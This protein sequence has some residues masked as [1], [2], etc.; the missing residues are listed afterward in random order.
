MISRRTKRVMLGL[1][2][3]ALT[4]VL[5]VTV[6]ARYFAAQERRQRIAEERANLQA[7]EPLSVTAARETRE[8]RRSYSAQLRPFA[9][10]R[11]AAEAQGRLDEILAQ[12]GDRVTQGQTLARI[13][14]TLA[15]LNLESAEATLAAAQAQLDE[16][17]RQLQD[18]EILG[19]SRA[20][21]EAEV[22]GLRAQLNVQEREVNRW[23]VETRRQAE[24]LARHQIRAPFDGIL[25][26]RLVE[27]GDTVALQ[28]PLLRVVALDPLRVIFFVSEAEISSFRSGTPIL[29]RLHSYPEREYSLTVTHVS[30]SADPRTGLF[31]LETWLP[32]PD[33]TLQ[34]GLVG[35]VEATVAVYR[36]TIFVPA[37][38]VRFDGPNA[39]IEVS[40]PEG[41]PERRRIEIGPDVGGSFPVLSGVAAGEQILIR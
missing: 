1:G 22:R 33:L 8:R 21:A 36:D 32:N 41:P 13:D 15:R 3:A 9:E 14:P 29:L 12:P 31:R 2:F 34:G 26:E 30:A 5:L 27:S 6:L 10:A 39:F 4:L 37:A 7:A 11:L 18:A 40:P 24:L 25:N 16:L 17:R 28:Q 19:A 38:A 23:D 35:T 20:I